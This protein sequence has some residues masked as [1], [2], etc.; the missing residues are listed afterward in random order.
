MFDSLIRLLRRDGIEQTNAKENF[1][2]S[3][4]SLPDYLRPGLNLVFVGL[5]PGLYS[6]QQ[7]KYY[8]RKTNRFWPALAA[9][10]LVDAEVKPGD[11]TMLVERG[12]GFTDVVKRA[13]GQID[14][15][16]PQ[17]IQSGAKQLRR[18]LLRYAPRAVCFVGLTGYR[19][20]F[21]LPAKIRVQPGPQAAQIGATRIY[22]LPSTSPAN[23]HFSF[24]EIT[25]EFRGLKAWLQASDIV[26]A[27]KKPFK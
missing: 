27:G 21:D 17:E 22:V 3:P 24:A 16:M 6:A 13:S 1:M 8:A 20:V 23:A 19:W 14:E 26:L 15:L 11:E 9:S 25:K 4:L 2:H 12:I 18:K 5:N 10:R 7:Q